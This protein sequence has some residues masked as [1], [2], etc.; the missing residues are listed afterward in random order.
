MRGKL[1]RVAAGARTVATPS[2][3]PALYARETAV[4][5]DAH[6]ARL[7]P[8]MRPALYARETPVESEITWETT[9]LQ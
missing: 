6:V 7:H 2:M 9:L 5:D 8:S 1:R 4:G 3:R